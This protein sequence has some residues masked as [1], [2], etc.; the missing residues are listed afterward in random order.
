MAG[1]DGS[2]IG[3]LLHRRGQWLEDFE[4]LVA[5]ALAIAMACVNVIA[6]TTCLV[7]LFLRQSATIASVIIWAGVACSMAW[8]LLLL[9]IYIVLGDTAPG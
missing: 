6:E 5:R 7:V 3:A 2:R 9:I 4:D 8:I 1:Q